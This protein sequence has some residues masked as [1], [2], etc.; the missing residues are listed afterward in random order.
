MKTVKF[1][2]PNQCYFFADNKSFFNHIIQLYVLLKITKTAT[3]Q[4]SK[5]RRD[6]RKTKTTAKYLNQF[7]QL[8]VGISNIKTSKQ[9]TPVC[10]IALNVSETLT[11]QIINLK[12]KYYENK[13]T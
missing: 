1:L 4:L 10:D 12:N 9:L 2:A 13:Q 6:N 3:N 5:L 8:H 7:L 11:E